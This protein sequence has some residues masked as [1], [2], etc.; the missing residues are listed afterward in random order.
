MKKI[1]SE[2]GRLKRKVRNRTR[3]ISKRV[4]A[5]ATA[6]RH[7]GEAGEAKR[8]KQY[9]ELLRYSR[10]ILNDT[11]RVI[12]EVEEMS[13]KKKKGLRGLC[14]HL[15][16]MAGRMRQV[17]KQTKVRVF[18]GITQMPGKIVSLFEPHSEI[19]RKGKAGK[20]TEFGK[21]VQVQEAE[22]Q[23]ITH[24]DVF[25]QRPSDR[26]LL[27]G[28]VESHE[29]VLGRVPHL[30]TADAGYYSRAQEQAVEDK[31][32]KWVAVPNRSTKSA[33][34]KK[35]EHSRWFRNAQRWRT[36]CEGRISVLKRRHGLSRCRYRG[37]EGMKRWV[38]LG[39]MA[40]TLIGMGNVLAA[41]T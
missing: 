35:K 23:I 21:L 17:V 5:I 37:N 6:S 39:V 30:A 9:K 31:G 10:Q 12:A 36:G 1:E 3:S 41:R 28:A 18:D 19:I 24:Y 34:R 25:D 13:A 4:V 26:D 15:S 20:P 16:E 27:L 29:R 2:A 11:K 40:D 8:R 33:D 32:V 14:E 38:G 7:K 22:N